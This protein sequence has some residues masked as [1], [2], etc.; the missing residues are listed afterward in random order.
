MENFYTKMRKF[1]QQSLKDVDDDGDDDGD[2]DDTRTQWE[3]R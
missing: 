2:A 1:T 3:S